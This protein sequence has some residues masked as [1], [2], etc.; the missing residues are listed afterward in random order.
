MTVFVDIHAIHSVPPSNLNRDDNGSPKTATFGGVRRHRVSSQSWKKAIRDDYN[1]RFAGA[2]KGFRT[3]NVAQL[4][5]EQIVALDPT[6]TVEAATES[7]VAKLISLAII[8]KT[9]A[10]KKEVTSDSL[11]LISAKQV[12]AI[13]RVI[14]NGGSD[15]E[16]KAAIKGENSLDL[17]L[18][19]RMVA[20]NNELNVEAASQ[21]AHAISTH[22]VANEFDYFTAVDDFSTSDHSGAAM[23]G[24]IEFASSTLYRFASINVN[25]LTKQFSNDDEVI[26]AALSGFIDSFVR[27]LP[28]GKQN[29]FAALSLPE[30]VV[31]SVR[32]DQPVSFV[33]A[34]EKPIRSSDEGY[35]DTSVKALVKYHQSVE[36]T[37]GSQDTSVIALATSDAAKESLASIAELTS[38]ADLKTKADG[39][40]V[41][42]LER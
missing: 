14:V 28:S 16:L 4:V 37:Y 39:L 19:G 30:A 36:N 31:V 42:K 41:S 23:M 20:S 38:L 7:A 2:N 34:F 40:A 35:S 3:V 27:A 21:F 12:E 32:T 25:A 9:R 6:Q 11:L 10:D 1:N 24:D 13:A 33:G 29:T 26:G 17:A 5:A 18:F 8:G 15:K 22:E